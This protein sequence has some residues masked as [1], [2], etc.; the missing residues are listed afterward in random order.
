MDG[1]IQEKHGFQELVSLS[2]T[3]SNETQGEAASR[4]KR[5]DRRKK[6]PANRPYDRSVSRPSPRERVVC[7]G[8]N[9][10]LTAS[11]EEGLLKRIDIAGGALQTL[12]NAPIGLG[13]TWNADGTIVYAPSTGS[14]LSRVPAGGGRAVDATRLN[15][16]QQMDHRFPYFLP[17]GRH[18]L[19]FARIYY[20]PT[21]ARVGV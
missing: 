7:S 14:P 5:T 13:G 12:A 18:F 15:P 19:F 21:R 11:G 16:P 4:S 6:N 17:D 2:V 10:D 8:K 1:S 9:P 20:I 3:M